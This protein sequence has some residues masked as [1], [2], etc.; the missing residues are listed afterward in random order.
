MA[1][2]TRR[3]YK[4][5][6]EPCTHSHLTLVD[7]VECARNNQSSTLDIVAIQNGR[8]GRLNEPEKE[9]LRIVSTGWDKTE[10]EIFDIQCGKSLSNLTDAERE[11]RY[12]EW[13]RFKAFVSHPRTKPPITKPPIKPYKNQYKCPH[14]NKDCGENAVY[15]ESCNRKFDEFIMFVGER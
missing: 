3:L 5:A 8:V 15:C 9:I 11:I 2:A 12:T 14:G 13:K 6:H 1:G 7:A 4:P 10:R